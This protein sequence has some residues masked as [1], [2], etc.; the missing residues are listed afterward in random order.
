ML[1]LEVN[2]PNV[3][4]FALDKLNYPYAFPSAW[5]CIDVSV[6]TGR[7]RYQSHLVWMSNVI[8]L[9]RIL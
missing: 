5:Q 9:S 4:V 6:K 3:K 2:F 1:K 8:R 7:Y